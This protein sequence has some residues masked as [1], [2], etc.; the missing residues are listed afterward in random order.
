MQIL[1]KNTNKK[2]MY[3]T[4][5][6]FSILLGIKVKANEDA[7]EKIKCERVKTNNIQG[8]EN[9]VEWEKIYEKDL[10]RNKY[11]I[12]TEFNNKEIRKRTKEIKSKNRL[13]QLG[14]S[15]PTANTL[16]KG[17]LKLETSH[18]SSFNGGES[19]GIGNQNY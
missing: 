5:L 16:S 17:D 10:N 13:L 3:I 15:V 19:S 6:I 9:V 18:V 7:S 2:L 1:F 14:K 8:E 11:K 12:K 4:I